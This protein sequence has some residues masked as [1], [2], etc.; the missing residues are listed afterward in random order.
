MRLIATKGY[1][2][3]GQSLKAGDPFEAYGFNAQQLIARGLAKAEPEQKPAPKKAEPAPPKP[4][5]EPA[6]L[7]EPEPPPVKRGPGRPRRVRMEEEPP[8]KMR[9]NNR[10][11]K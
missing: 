9:K 8:N 4:A 2:Y 10:R 5:P 1:R 6:P 11:T 7:E 3:R